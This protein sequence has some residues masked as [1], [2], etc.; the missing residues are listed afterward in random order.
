MRYQVALMGITLAVCSPGFAQDQ[1]NER[2]VVPAR[3]STHA[4]KLDV[5]LMGGSIVVKS[6]AGKEVIVEARD[7]GGSSS[8]VEDKRADGMRRLD[9]PQRGIS[10]EEQ[11]N[12]VTVRMQHGRRGSSV[13]I[14][15]PADT[16]LTLQTMGGDIEVDG[17]KG[18]MDL[19]SMN[20]KITLNNVS[21]SVLAHSMN[22]GM[23][24]VM[25]SVDA[26]KPLSFSTM[27]GTIDVTLPADFKANA[28]IRTDHGEVYSDFDFKLGGGAI[29][30]KNETSDGKFR[31]TM[32]RTITGTINGGGSEATFK[33]YNGTIYIRKKK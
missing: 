11:D 26:S 33:T 4:R 24:V 21:G 3:N 13:T 29:T 25:D 16:A 18:E 31:V 10:V 8:R 32:D 1:G 27:N 6:Y 14:S 9:L 15:T 2:V 22:G 30:Q 28:K 23:K 7:S 12:V 5:N 17:V 20:G 19:N